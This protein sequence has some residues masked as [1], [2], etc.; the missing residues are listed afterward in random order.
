VNASVITLSRLRRLNGEPSVYV[1]TYV[2][3]ELCP[4]LLKMD[5]ENRSLYSFLDSNGLFIHTGHRYIGVS[6]ANEYEASLLEIEA[7]SPLIELDSVSF[8]KDGR[9]IEYFHALHRGDRTIFEVD[10]IKFEK[11]PGERA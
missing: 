1:T 3:Y 11:S 10:L 6:L 7:G 8:L 4:Q 5:M 2:P 9:P